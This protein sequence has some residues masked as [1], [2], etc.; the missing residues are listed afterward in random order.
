MGNNKLRMED[1]FHLEIVTLYDDVRASDHDDDD[2]NDNDGGTLSNNKKKG[3]E[4]AEN[5][6]SSYKFY[7]R[8]STVG[9]VASSVAS[10]LGKDVTSEFLVVVYPPIT[11]ADAAA[12]GCSDA[13]HQKSNSSDDITKKRYR[14]LP[15][16]M[17]LHDA[18][19]AGYLNEFDVVIVRIYSLLSGESSKDDEEEYYNGPSKSV[20]DPESDNDDDCD[21]DDVMDSNNDD[22]ANDGNK[23][24]NANLEDGKPTAMDVDSERATTTSISQQNQQ[25]DDQS[26]QLLQQRMH[27]IFQS[28]EHDDNDSNPATAKKKKKKKPVSKQVHNM[29][30]KPKATGNP[31]I[32]QEDRIYLE[33][34]LVFDDIGSVQHDNI[35]SSYRYFSTKNDVQHILTVC[36]SRTTVSSDNAPPIMVEELVVQISAT[37]NTKI[38]DSENAMSYYSLPKTL[39]I[40]EAIQNGYLDNFGRVLIRVCS[41]SEKNNI[42]LPCLR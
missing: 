10:N 34:V 36:N 6:S 27:A 9:K 7:P 15:N 22:D 17:S 21:D 4:S 40:E 41:S 24:E 13:Q 42:T 12:G 35:S 26:Q 18:Q 1:R 3:S 14:R 28:L 33:V 30:I 19:V 31:R 37:D 11:S 16:T 5:G 39:T 29:L 32:K 25:S 23:D 8:Q 2:N 20:L 38:N